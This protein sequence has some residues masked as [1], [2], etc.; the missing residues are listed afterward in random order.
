MTISLVTGGAGF[1]GSH[2]VDVLLAQ[3]QQVRVLDNFIS[4]TPTNLPQSA[5]RLEI[6]PG[7]LNDISVLD[8]AAEG[9]D[10]VFHVA[11]APFTSYSPNASPDRW[12]STT[13]TLNVL[14]AA[15][16]ARVKRVVYS[17]CESVYGSATAGPVSE[18]DPTLPL[19]PY[20]F[21]KL[22]G[23][24]QCVAFSG[25]YG[26]ETVRLRYFNVFGPRQTTSGARPA[27]IFLILKAMLLGQHPVIEGDG[28]EPQDFIYVD[29]VVHANLLAALAPRL[30]GKVY[31]IA[32]GRPTTLSAVVAAIN[33][34]LRTDL[35]PHYTDHCTTGRYP[36][37]AKTARAEVE[38]GFC[39]GTDLEQGL[40]RCIA[41]YKARPEELGKPTRSESHLDRGPHFA[42]GGPEKPAPAVPDGL[43]EGKD[44]HDL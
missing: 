21:A 40:R 19:S 17:S 34:L 30:A 18:S 15:H 23:E 11:M 43:T 13:D 31:N 1:V 35:Q 5:P 12:A 20:A 41:Y 29:D 7:D 10:Y 8:Q 14:M 36:R 42:R 26:M 25:I 2:L 22:T 37:I 28:Q 27:A 32:C 44:E 39:P 38:L 6:I 3:G 4:G 16:R 9:V 24:Q 33:A